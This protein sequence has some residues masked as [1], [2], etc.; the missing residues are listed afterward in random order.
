MYCAQLHNPTDVR[1]APGYL[2]DPRAAVSCNEHRDPVP[3]G[4]ETVPANRAH[5]TTLRPMRSYKSLDSWKACHALTLGL[6]QA[7]KPLLEQDPELAERLRLAALLSA[8]KLA[9]GAGTGNRTVM[10]QCAEQSAGHLAEVGY[11]LELAR[12]LD[13]IPPDACQRLDALRGRAAFYLWKEL[14][15]GPTGP[16][17]QSRSDVN[18]EGQMH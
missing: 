3:C 12:V 18:W 10:R 15:A 8:C 7:T 4:N 14:L 16:K 6:Y 17:K 11:Q 5:G 9:R 1:R 2:L 13:L